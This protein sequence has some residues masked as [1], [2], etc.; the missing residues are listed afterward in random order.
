MLSLKV[1]YKSDCEK[2]YKKRN[3]QSNKIMLYTVDV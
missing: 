2:N 3:V 1:E